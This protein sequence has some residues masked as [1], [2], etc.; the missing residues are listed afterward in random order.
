MHQRK[1]ALSIALG[2]MLTLAL[3]VAFSLSQN[4]AMASAVAPE[5]SPQIG[6]DEAIRAQD[7]VSTAH[8]VVVFSEEKTAVRSISWTET[9][10]RVG[11]LRAAGFSVETEDSSGAICNINGDGCPASDCFCS[12][13]WW[14]QGGWDPEQEQWDA[15]WPLPD[16]ADGDVLGFRNSTAWGAPRFPAPSYVAGLK[17]LDWLRDQQ[18]TDGGFGSLNATAE[19]LMAV[20]ANR[21]DASTWRGEGPS[22]L[23]NMLSEGTELANRNASGVGKLAT[24]LAA[25]QSCWPIDAMRPLDYYDPVSG[26]FSHDTLY[27]AWAMLGT[28][29]LGETVPPSATQH[30]KEVQ[31]PDGGWEW[32]ARQGTDTN[33]TALAL[34][35]LAAAGEPLTST[36]VVSGL[37]YLDDAQ[38]ED[39]GFPYSPNSP[40]G[41]PVS[42]ANSTAYV[43]QAL[44]ATGQD[45]L[46]GTWAIT[47]TNP[48]SYLLSLQ[49]PDGSFEWQAGTGADVFATRQ[50]IPALLHQPFPLQITTAEDCYGISGKVVSSHQTTPSASAQGSD[51]GIA[52]VTVWAQGAGDLY[53]ATTVDPTGA[54][55]LSVPSTGTYT[56]SPSYG[57]YVFTPREHTVKVTGDPG[58]VSSGHV[59]VGET[60]IYL[61]LV[62]RN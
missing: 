22:L 5:T 13:N 45:A 36:T 51:D 25:Q 35:A 39:G 53:F 57:D 31:Q 52:D 41:P 28:S 21:V 3:L 10:S 42:D 8:V 54:Y 59:F 47:N 14:W 44:V 18:Q 38:N 40:C 55:T 2:A 34:Q 24:A 16:P 19:T 37:N 56:L 26:T 15:P 62:M 30:L 27:Q 50:V 9:I 12:E 32:A 48:V 43:L 23:A 20:G 49:L 58:D 7:A 33:S 1:L 4:S 17:A 11:A 29:A 61:A 60:R 46:T 6:A